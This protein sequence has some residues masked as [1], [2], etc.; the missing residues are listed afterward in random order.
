M[1][2]V[3]LFT[4]D[5]TVDFPVGR[6]LD[7]AKDKDIKTIVVIGLKEDNSLYFAS[8]VADVTLMLWMCEKLKHA[9]MK[10]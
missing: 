9:L 1:T 5:T 2:N 8:S 10:E 6:V 4:G 7:G 3:I